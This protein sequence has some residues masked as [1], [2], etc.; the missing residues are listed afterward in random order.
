M[1]VP[2]PLGSN[3]VDWFLGMPGKTPKIN[4][5]T[6]VSLQES[7]LRKK[8]KSFL[9]ATGVGGFLVSPYRFK[10]AASYHAPQI[11]QALS[12]SFR[13]R[14]YTNFTYELTSENVE[15]LA[16][17]V[18]A[19]TGVCYSAARAYISELENDEALKA[20][21]IERS[22][23]GP[24]QHYSDPTCAFGR[25][26]GWYA[27]ARILKPSI[28]V[29]TGIDKGLG[30][31]LL[32]AALLRNRSEGHPGTYFGTD[33]NHSAGFLLS[34]A[35]RD[36]GHILYGDSIES[37]R[38]ITSIDLFINDSDH[39][40]DYERREY[41]TIAAVLTPKAI[42]LGDNAHCTAELARF[43]VK[44]GRK[45]LFFKEQPKDHWYPGAGIGISY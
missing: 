1:T 9:K 5:H 13:T 29:E 2:F 34:D 18:A 20:H 41:E 17:T 44:H 7:K 39:S 8:I 3:P 36:V 19:V 24:E 45:F 15:Y 28:V 22:R 11:V 35:Y 38:G 6:N 16:H 30:S 10:I 43:S 40:A 23:K 32:C 12:W 21:V 14:E 42:I 37:L 31:V 33:I 27:F 4:M 26:L 25:R